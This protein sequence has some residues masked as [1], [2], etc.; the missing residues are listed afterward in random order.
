[1][2]H[3]EVL[4]GNG[5]CDGIGSRVELLGPQRSKNVV[6]VGG[7]QWSPRAASDPACYP[8][9]QKPQSNGK[10]REPAATQIFRLGYLWCYDCGSGGDVH[11]VLNV[12]ACECKRPESCLS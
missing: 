10:A 5:L 12:N 8:P 2:I 4:R 7:N 3:L 1:M 9:V 6:L 11:Y